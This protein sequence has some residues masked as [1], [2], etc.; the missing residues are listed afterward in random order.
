MVASNCHGNETTPI[1]LWNLQPM[2]VGG[3]GGKE[4]VGEWGGEEGVSSASSSQYNELWPS[5]STVEMNTLMD[6]RGEGGEVEGEWGEGGKGEGEGGEEREV[7]GEEGEEEDEVRKNRGGNNVD[8]A[9]GQSTI[10]KSV[11]NAHY[12]FSDSIKC[13]YSIRVHVAV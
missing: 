11:Y 13:A 1:T 8:G 4:R 10:A 6:G 5:S 3:M 12:K 7:M 2:C 9:T